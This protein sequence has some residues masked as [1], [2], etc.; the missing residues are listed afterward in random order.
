MT[1]LSFRDMIS[2]Y[3]TKMQKA[4]LI[5]RENAG[6]MLNVYDFMPPAD[7][8][9]EAE[10]LIRALREREDG[11]VFIVEDE[12]KWYFPYYIKVARAIA[13]GKR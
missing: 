5:A 1:S 8:E 2:G 7:N 6:E 11:Y 10:L 12:K 13:E 3:D 9:K 4:E